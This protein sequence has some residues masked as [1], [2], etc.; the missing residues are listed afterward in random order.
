[1]PNATIHRGRPSTMPAIAIPDTI[2]PT[3]MGTSVRGRAW[4]DA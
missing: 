3:E 2:S 4:A 1:M